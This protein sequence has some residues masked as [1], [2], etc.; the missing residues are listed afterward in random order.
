MSC[1][2]VSLMSYAQMPWPRMAGRRRHLM[3]TRVARTTNHLP[4]HRPHP[5]LCRPAA[6]LRPMHP[7]QPRLPPLRV[8]PLRPPPRRR[9]MHHRAPLL[10]MAL[11]LPL[12][13]TALQLQ[14]LQTALQLQ[15]L[16]TALPLQLLRVVEQHRPTAPRL[17]PRRRPVAQMLLQAMHPPRHLQARPLLHLRHRQLPW[18]R[19]QRRPT[20]RSPMTRRPLGA[21]YHD[22]LDVRIAELA[23]SN[24]LYNDVGSPLYHV[25]GP[26]APCAGPALAS[27]LPIAFLQ[28]MGQ[29][30]CA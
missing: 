11:R 14:R 9:P 19:L 29:P 25:A 8:T 2:P 30:V 12:L 10:R 6:P 17:V 26:Y 24:P 27:H 18:R 4:L 15:R 7:A 16:Q 1:D 3:T 5:L 28:A 22:T 23:G 21:L 20:P 13:R